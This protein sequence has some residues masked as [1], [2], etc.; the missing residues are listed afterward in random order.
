MKKITVGLMGFGTVGSGM[1]KILLENQEVI[2]PRLGASLVLK[3]I[4]DLD[5]ERDRGVD[6]DPGIL[7]QDAEVVINDKEVDIVVELIGGY[8]PARSLLLKAIENGKHIVTANKALL[9][10]HGDEI[11]SA[12]SQKGVEVGFEASVGGGIPLIRSIKEGLV[13][14]R[15]EGLFGILNGTANYILTKMTDEGSPFSEVL[16]EAQALGYAEADPTFDVEGIDAA[17]KLTI[18]LSIAYGVPI[19]FKAV[20]TEGI[21]KV[22]PLDIRFIQEFGYRIKL[23]AISKDDGEAIEARVHP[24]LMP[25]DSMLANVNEAY[26][27]LYIKGDAVGNVMLYGPGAGMMPTGSAVVSDLVDVARN[28][29][30]DAA[31]RVPSVGYQPSGIK[32]RRIKSIE[33]LQTEYYFRFSAEDRPGVLS[34]VAGILGKHQISIKSVHQQG[35]DLAGAVPIVMITHEAREAAVQVALS[36]IQQ[37]DVVKDETILIRIEDWR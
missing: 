22:T 28:I 7:T 13:A 17:H 34:K 1:A 23:L 36:E 5:L 4:A 25:D 3:W 24:T 9:A 27:A 20:Y 35:R 26:N 16:K 8:E 6:V 29:L 2:E 11:F 19:D 33:E 37:L 10:I 15:I 14:N 31:G 18:L 12:A 21:S 32:Q 30:R